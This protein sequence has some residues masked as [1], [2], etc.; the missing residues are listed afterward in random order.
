LDAVRVTV[1]S[2]SGTRFRRQGLKRVDPATSAG[3]SEPGY[4][5][6]STSKGLE[7]DFNSID[8]QRE[9]CE[10]YVAAQQHDGW[11]LLADRYDDGGFTGANLDRPGFR[12]LMAD[13]EAGAVDVV[14]VY[15]V[16]RLSRSLLDF[17]RL[18]DRFEQLDVAFVSVTQSFSTADAMG[19][20]TLNILLSF[21]QFEREMI[22][23][24][25]RD[26]IQAARRRGKWT[27]GPVPLGCRTEDKKLVVDE[28]EAVVVRR[29]F[30]LYLE[31]HSA[32]AVVRELRAEGHR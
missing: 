2:G 3:A 14:V 26:K 28:A 12:R 24:R 6:K 23:E 18:M 17:A 21:A 13:I 7:Q 30:G 5:S 11:R 10:R 27:G 25:T 16:D 8:A 4:G 31:H 22:G 9:A 1:V 29:A 32:D 20:L 19:R 15:K